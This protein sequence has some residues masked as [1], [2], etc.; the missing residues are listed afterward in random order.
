LAGLWSGDFVRVTLPTGLRLPV[1]DD[2]APG[3]EVGET[4]RANLDVVTCGPCDG[5][6]RRSRNELAASAVQDEIAW[7]RS[8]IGVEDKSVGIGVWPGNVGGIIVNE[9]GHVSTPGWREYPHFPIIY[10]GVQK[11]R[12][13][14][15]VPLL[16]LDSSGVEN[17]WCDFPRW[18]EV[19]RRLSSRPVSAR[20]ARWRTRRDNGVHQTPSCEVTLPPRCRPERSRRTPLPTASGRRSHDRRPVPAL[21]RGYGRQERQPRRWR[22]RSFDFAQDDT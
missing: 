21:H 9:D 11:K 1:N 7:M 10:S 22:T 19:P 14:R 16:R 5:S 4:G 17:L 20:R 6:L 8:A 12:P 18:P 15:H 3:R 13:S 2:L